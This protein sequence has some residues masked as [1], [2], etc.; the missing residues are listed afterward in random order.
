[1]GICRHRD[2]WLICGGTT[3]W[4]YRCGSIRRLSQG[5]NYEP[6]D[7]TSPPPQNAVYAVS[8][9]CSPVG[10]DGQNPFGAWDKRCAA[11]L[12]ARATRRKNRNASV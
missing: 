2:S 9:W 10:S 5:G 8:P 6:V 11:Y 12:K 7:G 4:C 1:M 3:E